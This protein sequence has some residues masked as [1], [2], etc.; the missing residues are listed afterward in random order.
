MNS[1]E[2]GTPLKHPETINGNVKN[3]SKSWHFLYFSSS[4]LVGISFI[5]HLHKIKEMPTKNEDEK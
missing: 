1:D 4:S 2:V 5:F 3:L